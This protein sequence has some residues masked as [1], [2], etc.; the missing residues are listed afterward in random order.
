[1]TH[2]TA[3]RMVATLL[4]AALLL[5]AA[6]HAERVVTRDASRDVVRLDEVASQEANHEVVVA[7]P[8]STTTDITRVVVDHRAGLLRVAV[9]VRDLRDDT[10]ADRVSVRLRSQERLFE[11]EAMRRGRHTYTSMT[12]GHRG[13]G[14]TCGGLVTVVD[15]RADT[16]VVSVPTMCIEDPRW[17]RVGANMLGVR[18]THT[19]QSGDESILLMDEAGVTGFHGDGPPALGPKVRRD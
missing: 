4:P 18:V 9:H 14:K 5:P 2:R 19:S 7:E 10:F 16:L 13:T 15:S 3:A 12:R 17:V 11:I 8:R 1:M 6:A